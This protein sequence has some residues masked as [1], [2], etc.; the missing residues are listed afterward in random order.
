[1][2]VPVWVA[3]GGTPDALRRNMSIR[4][5]AAPL[6]A[7][8]LVKVDGDLDMEGV[9]EVDAVCGSAAGPVVLDLTDLKSF[10]SDGEECLRRLLDGGAT[11]TAAAPYIR[12]RLGLDGT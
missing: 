3:P 10:D 2:V 6:E 7:G 9:G 4:I 11:V 8:T 1:M 12:V 5:W